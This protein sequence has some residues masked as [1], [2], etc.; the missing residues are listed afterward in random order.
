MR[1]AVGN[2]SYPEYYLIERAE[3][4]FLVTDSEKRAREVFGNINSYKEYFNVDTPVLFI[5]S[6]SDPLDIK[7]QIERNFAY[8]N[9]LTKDRFVAVLS[10]DALDLDIQKRESFLESIIKIETGKEVDRQPIVEKLY[11]LGY[12]YTDEVL[13]EGEFS[14]KGNFITVYLPY[15]GIVEIDLWGN[16]VENIFLR[17]KLSTRKR[18][19]NI[20]IQPLYDRPLESRD[21]IIF[22]DVP[23][24]K[25][26]EI[27]TGEVYFLDIYHELIDFK[28]GVYF[29]SHQGSDFSDEK[30]TDD[31]QIIKLP[32]TRKLVLRSEKK[33]FVPHITLKKEFEYEPLNIGDYVI[34]EEFGIGIYRGIQTKEVRGKLYDFMVLEYAQDEK[35]LVSYLHFDK[36]NKYRSDGAVK[37]D[38]I[39]SPTW[40]NLKKKIKAS[41]REIAKQLLKLY[42]ERRTTFRN[43]LDTD[44][45]IVK[46][47][48]EDFEYPETEDQRRAILDIKMDFKKTIPMDRVLCGDVGFGK[49]EV[50]LRASVIAVSNGCQVAIVVPTTVLSYQ[51][52]QKFKSRLEKFGIV[53]ENLSRLRSVQEQM[54]ILKRIKDGRIDIVVGTHRLLQDDVNFKNLGLL[55]VDEEHRFGVRAK[56]KLRQIKKDVDTLYISATPIPRTVNLVVSKLKDI[57]VINTPPEGR[58]EIKTI[59]SRF[60]ENI[61]KRAIKYEL[62]RNGQVFFLH[63]RVES[64]KERVS[65][66]KDLFPQAE[67]EFIHAKMKPKQI[68]ERILD[69]IEG[70]FDI[71][72]STSII[73]TGIDIPT[74]NTLIVERADLFGLT[75]LYHL[76][77]RVGRKDQQGYCYLLLPKEITEDAKERMRVLSRLTRPGSG[78]KISMEDLKIRGPGNILGV[79]QS[80]FIK[81]VGM[82]MYMRML[83]EAIEEER[84]ITEANVLVDIDVD[85]SIPEDFVDNPEERLNIYMALSKVNDEDEIDSLRDYLEKFYGGL[86][87]ALKF[88]LNFKKLEKLSPKLKLIKI[89]I[90]GGVLKLTFDQISPE[91][92]FNLI[93]VLKPISILKDTLV[94]DFNIH[95]FDYF[96]EEIENILKRCKI[97]I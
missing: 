30:N 54:D 86:P 10:K 37:I 20:I 76:R 16:F 3:K 83:K 27:V 21:P 52:Y 23:L 39:G 72:V 22:K 42:S 90:K 53:V 32:V 46:M 35:V 95:T 56:E 15:I 12:I 34:H 84:G 25:F 44:N 59:I 62:D 50:A 73:E 65:Y 79:E 81:A 91:F 60:D 40:K 67:V 97:D 43:P 41:L 80:G 14:V 8:M 88:Y 85:M 61:I 5:P 4:G 92:L 47:V 94:F 19:E 77:G 45:E 31:F 89:Q 82:Q 78:F 66:I 9:I 96:V 69:F 29:Y 87:A 13:D 17:S 6:Y 11:R 55:I 1:I 71:L 51:H 63:N 24:S 2:S 57:S 68:E 49:T 26:R 28:D 70:R 58:M 75:Q 36:I 18:I 7:S 38:K 33:I 93:D 48:E 64:I 74:A